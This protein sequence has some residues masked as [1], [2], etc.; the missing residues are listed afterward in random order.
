MNNYC[1]VFV[2]IIKKRNIIEES[3][4]IQRIE[5][6]GEILSIDFTYLTEDKI[7]EII[8]ILKNESNL[9]SDLFNEIDNLKTKKFPVEF[10]YK[11]F[12]FW[13]IFMEGKLN[14]KLIPIFLLY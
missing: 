6:T 7:E 11:I 1:Q 10:Y 2:D 3:V 13:D 8:K 4:K 5:D 12:L 9:Y 14:E